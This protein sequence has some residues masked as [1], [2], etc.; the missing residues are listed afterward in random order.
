[1]SNCSQL[2][3][4]APPPPTTTTTTEPGLGKSAISVQQ[5]KSILSLNL[6]ATLM[7]I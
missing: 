3:M 1:M 5:L 4:L 2:V 6:M 7:I